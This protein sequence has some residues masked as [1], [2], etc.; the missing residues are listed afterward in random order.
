VSAGPYAASELRF[1]PAVTKDTVTTQLVPL[2]APSIATLPVSTVPAVPATATLAG[3][4]Y[5]DVVAN[6]SSPADD[7]GF[8]TVKHKIKTQPKSPLQI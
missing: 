5:R 4:S 1:P 3:L 8:K 7:E 6:G 2:S